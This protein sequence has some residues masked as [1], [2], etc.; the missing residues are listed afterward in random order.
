[1]RS[2]YGAS[3]TFKNLEY[4]CNKRRDR[5]SAAEPERQR[6]RVRERGEEMGGDRDRERQIHQRMPGQE[7]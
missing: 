4:A 1:M 2:C 5:G 7:R 3:E 6:V